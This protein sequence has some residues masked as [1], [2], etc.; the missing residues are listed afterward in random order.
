MAAK[1]YINAILKE[2]DKTKKFRKNVLLC[3][4]N[5]FFVKSL[6]TVAAMSNPAADGTK[7]TEAGTRHVVSG[8]CEVNAFRGCSELHTHNRRG[9]PSSRSLRRITFASGSVC[10]L[11]IS[12]TRKPIGSSLF[13]APMQLIRGTPSLWHRQISSIFAVTVSMQSST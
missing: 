10:V 9:I 3:L 4:R 7:A 13:A 8:E 12:V 6:T 5:Y 1:I 11:D 2:T